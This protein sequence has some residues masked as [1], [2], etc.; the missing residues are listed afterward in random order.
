MKT[1]SPARCL[2]LI[3]ALYSI[4]LLSD[5]I[6]M[7]IACMLS[8]AMVVRV[9]MRSS[10]FAS[11]KDR[12]L[13]AFVA[14][15]VVSSLASGHFL[16][17][18]LF[19]VSGIGA[20]LL[21]SSAAVIRPAEARTLVRAFHV[22]VF[23]EV[24]LVLGKYLLTGQ[25]A[26]GDWAHVILDGA[27]LSGLSMMFATTHILWRAIQGRR[28]GLLLI[29]IPYLLAIHLTATNQGVLAFSAGMIVVAMY[30]NRLASRL[31]IAVCAML[32]LWSFGG[33][34]AMGFLWDQMNRIGTD[35]P[36]VRGYLATAEMYRENPLVAVVGAGPGNYGS[37]AAVARS[38]HVDLGKPE[39]NR[40]P[41]SFVGTPP[42]LKAYLAEYYNPEYV[43]QVIRAGISGTY[44]TP[45]STWNAVLGEL[46]VTG[47]VVLLL[48]LWRVFKEGLATARLNPKLGAVGYT[49]A[50]ACVALLI[51]FAY[52]NWLEYPKVMIPFVLFA[53]RTAI[54]Q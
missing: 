35:V 54:V 26:R 17:G 39:G 29:C 42:A 20:L 14:L 33:L 31:L 1:P 32:A 12:A 50:V 19:L 24:T 52:D 53:N 13:V 27:H 28:I 22:L 9:L 21:L 44:Y 45:F 47:A 46:G 10:G 30:R 37:R 25:P 8:F 34:E 3:V 7:A 5:P 36:K 49:S 4:V 38:S 43:D 18:L 2:F 48:I 11:R 16:G 23:V 15:A 6:G 51:L 41:E 40:I